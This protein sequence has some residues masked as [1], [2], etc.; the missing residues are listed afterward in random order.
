MTISSGS[1]PGIIRSKPMRLD[2]LNG[3]WKK[4][5]AALAKEGIAI[6]FQ[7][8]ASVEPHTATIHVSLD[9]GERA[10]AAIEAAGVSWQEPTPYY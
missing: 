10:A 5:R 3:D 7:S 8:V 9:D 6:M 1:K 4:A 2:Y